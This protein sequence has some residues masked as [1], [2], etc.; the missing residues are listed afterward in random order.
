MFIFAILY[1]NFYNLLMRSTGIIDL[2]KSKMK[3]IH[4]TD[5]LVAI[6][7]YVSIVQGR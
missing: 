5:N 1:V 3:E 4:M 7:V 2:L 6:Y